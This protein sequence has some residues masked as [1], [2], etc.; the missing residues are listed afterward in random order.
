MS[1]AIALQKFAARA[2]VINVND[3]ERAKH[4][5]RPLPNVGLAS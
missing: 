2:G 4:V 3:R 1:R 5:M